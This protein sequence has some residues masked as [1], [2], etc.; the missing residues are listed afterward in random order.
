[1]STYPNSNNDPELLKIK[2][3]DDEVKVSKYKSEK[4]NHEKY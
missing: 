1:M 2:T 4:H 3:K